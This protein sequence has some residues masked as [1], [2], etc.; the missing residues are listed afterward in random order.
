MCIGADFQFWVQG[1]KEVGASG[2]PFP[3]SGSCETHDPGGGTN[4]NFVRLIC[5][6]CDRFQWAIIYSNILV[7]WRGTKFSH[8]VWGKNP[9]SRS[10][11]C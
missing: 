8:L 6:I 11:Q 5:I 10:I 3:L 7:F 2:P 4:I 1:L 9:T